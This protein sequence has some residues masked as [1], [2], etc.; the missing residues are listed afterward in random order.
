VLVVLAFGLVL[1]VAAAV[2]A[3][4][5]GGTSGSGSTAPRRAVKHARH[6]SAVRVREPL[7]AREIGA[8]RRY[9]PFVSI[10]S[11]RHRVVALTFD[12]GPSP[13]TGPIVRILARMHAPAT[14]FVVGQQL[15]YF[16]GG[17]RDE[18]RHGFEVGDHTENHAWLAHL[19]AAGQY[20]QIRDDAARMQRAGAPAPRLFRP[21]YGIYN[22]TTL[23]ILRRLRML[24]VMWS[25]DPGDWRRP[26]TKAIVSGVL[27]HA[28]PGAVVILH[29]GGGDRTQTIGALPA[30]IRGLRRRGYRLVT[31]AKLIALDP[32]P[33]HQKLP[34]LGAA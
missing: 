1:G 29:D 10:G 3:A 24:M 28:K 13:Y 27:A 25:I 14:F 6:H 30:I 8:V 21:P 9:T 7:D 4:T 18:V 2:M 11:R 22:R 16:A 32:P 26:G 12:D 33:R 31:V 34:H 19:G 15:R 5:H 20:G 17:L 23:G